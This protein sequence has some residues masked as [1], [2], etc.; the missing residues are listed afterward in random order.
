MKNNVFSY[1]V[2]LKKVDRMILLLYE[3]TWVGGAM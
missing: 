2:D 3:V 1:Y